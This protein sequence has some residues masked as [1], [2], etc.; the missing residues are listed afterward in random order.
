V[1]ALDGNAVLV[2]CPPSV[3]TVGWFH[4]NGVAAA[5][6]DNR[7]FEVTPFEEPYDVTYPLHSRLVRD[8]G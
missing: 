8:L 3:S 4:R 2:R 1:L 6:V 5:A 7:T